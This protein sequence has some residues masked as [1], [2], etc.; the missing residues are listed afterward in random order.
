MESCFCCY[1]ILYFWSNELTECAS[2][3]A[4]VVLKWNSDSTSDIVLNPLNTLCTSVLQEPSKPPST[5]RHPE[6][7][8]KDA[9][10]AGK[11]PGGY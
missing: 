6:V 8:K 2:C 7:G 3:N 4:C 10:K 1:L 9:G 5:H 11:K